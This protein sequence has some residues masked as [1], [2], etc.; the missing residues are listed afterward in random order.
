M[1]EWQQELRFVPFDGT[2]F[3]CNVREAGQGGDQDHQTLVS[4][5]LTGQRSD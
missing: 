5:L 2:A 4:A 1:E 3:E